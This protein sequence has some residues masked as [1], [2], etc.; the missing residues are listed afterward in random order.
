[1]RSVVVV[2]VVVVVVGME[3]SKGNCSCPCFDVSPSPG[4][5]MRSCVQQSE[6][7]RVRKL[8][9]HRSWLGMQCHPPLLLLLLAAVSWRPDEWRDRTRQKPPFSW[10]AAAWTGNLRQ[11]GTG[12]RLKCV[13]VATGPYLQGR[14]LW[15]QRWY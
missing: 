13:W 1:M 6:N 11:R 10:G 8:F 7:E 2:V 12:W 3:V 15:N 5:P 9:S 4:R 14:P